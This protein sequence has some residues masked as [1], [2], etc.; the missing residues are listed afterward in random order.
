MT[1]DEPDRPGHTPQ[2]PAV[3]GRLPNLG[4]VQLR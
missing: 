1:P 3:G 2:N 4:E